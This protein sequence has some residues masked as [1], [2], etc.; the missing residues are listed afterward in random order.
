MFKSALADVDHFVRY[1]TAQNEKGPGFMAASTKKT[2]TD[3]PVS[4]PKARTNNAVVMMLAVFALVA[5]ACGQAAVETSQDVPVAE[6]AVVE[7]ADAPTDTESGSVDEADDAVD[8]PEP[9]AQEAGGVEDVTS[10][11]S[12]VP[13]DWDPFGG[14]TTSDTTAV[15]T[16]PAPAESV[17]ET[18]AFSADATADYQTMLVT[19]ETEI[20]AGEDTLTMSGQGAVDGNTTAMQVT[21]GGAFTAM[22]RGSGLN[23][24]TLGQPMTIIADGQHSFVKWKV[25]ND[26]ADLGDTWV[27]AP[28]DADTV[29]LMDQTI[30]DPSTYLDMLYSAGDDVKEV[31]TK[32]LG[33][34]TVTGYSGSFDTGDLG[35]NSD[36]Q[37]YVDGSGS[38]LNDVTTTVWIDDD[39]L[40]RQ[41][42]ADYGIAGLFYRTTIT[43]S[44]YGEPVNIDVPS[45]SDAVPMSALESTLG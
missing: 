29:P 42:E 19:L 8:E 1:A 14:D 31:G 22:F 3:S 13:E 40:V 16:V 21:F 7:K 2:Q 36:V 15:V 12:T 18:L 33:G 23:R 6:V 32:E 9:A 34:R 17:P 10:T 45:T 43:F 11:P 38:S 28:V 25:L 24:D 35:A 39:D 41:I 44:A 4:P 27:F 26:L 37:N 5:A 20:G 30:Y